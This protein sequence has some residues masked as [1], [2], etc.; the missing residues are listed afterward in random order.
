M[1]DAPGKGW[2]GAAFMLLRSYAADW[3][4]WAGGLAS[5]YG[6]A[7]AL[8]VGGA[9]ALFAAIAVGIT[10]LFDLLERTYGIEIAYAAIGGGLFVL[11]IVLFL[12]GWMMLR[13][14][15]RPLPRPRRQMEAARQV[16]GGPAAWRVIGRKLG[17]NAAQTDPVT[18]LL[19][20]AAATLLVGWMV[21][22]RLQS[23]RRVSR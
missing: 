12:I 18:G 21:A 5:R 11:A 16:L 10:A 4:R 1:H 20:G 2:R 6:I 14:K 8:L 9:L 15:V 19:F 13:R 3:R 23:N 17:A 22:S 7:I